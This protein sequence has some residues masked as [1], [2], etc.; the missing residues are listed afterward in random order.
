L[1]FKAPTARERFHRR[2][3]QRISRLVISSV[4]CVMS[5]IGAGAGANAE[6]SGTSLAIAYAEPPLV[7]IKAMDVPVDEVLKQ[8]ADRLH[9]QIDLPPPTENSPRISG[10]FKAD[11]ADMLRRV[12]LRDGNYVVFYRG[13]AIERIVI[14]S[15]GATAAAASSPGEASAAEDTRADDAAAVAE[16][17]AEADRSQHP[18]ARLLEAQASLVR[19]PGAEAGAG[20]GAGASGSA[21]APQPGSAAA[22]G[23]QGSLAAMTRTAQTNVLMLVKALQSVCIGPACSQ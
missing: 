18:L 7:T 13:A 8:L 2:I 5:L 9:F 10:S 14:T 4:L 11:I 17:R 21:P 22:A 12:L 15:W 3:A 1:F 6:G 19:P 23:A 16:R 20:G